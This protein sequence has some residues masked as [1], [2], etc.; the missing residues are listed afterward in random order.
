MTTRTETRPDPSTS[1][2]FTY[3]FIGDQFPNAT[4]TL[5]RT[6]GHPNT[7]KAKVIGKGAK[8]AGKV[9]LEKLGLEAFTPHV[10]PAIDRVYSFIGHQSERSQVPPEMEPPIQ[11]PVDRKN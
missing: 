9:V 4:D 8:I 6:M 2:A 7:L 3:G 11:P 10:A 1:A 5:S